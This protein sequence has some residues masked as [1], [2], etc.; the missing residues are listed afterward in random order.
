MRIARR[1]GADRGE[2]ARADDGADAKGD[3][4]PWPERFLELVAFFL[5]SGNELVERLG[6]EQ[7]ADQ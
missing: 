5:R 3:E 1:G 4:I 6:G 2:D 7:T